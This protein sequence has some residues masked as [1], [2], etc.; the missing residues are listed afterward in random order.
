MKR[1]D[2]LS[3]YDPVSIFHRLWFFYPVSNLDT[4]GA[5]D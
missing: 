5:R 2:N 1:A 4:L 3:L